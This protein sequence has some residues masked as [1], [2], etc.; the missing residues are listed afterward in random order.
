[1][2]GHICYS[3]KSSSLLENMRTVDFRGSASGKNKFVMVL[4][5]K[6]EDEEEN[7]NCFG[8]G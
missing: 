7:N 6:G 8:G 2:A 3:H 5:N 1:M 4:K